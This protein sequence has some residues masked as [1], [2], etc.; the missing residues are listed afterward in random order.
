M[1]LDEMSDMAES[2]VTRAHVQKRNAFCIFDKGVEHKNVRLGHRLFMWNRTSIPVLA[3]HSRHHLERRY[4]DK[5]CKS[6]K[7][8]GER[9]RTLKC[10]IVSV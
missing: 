5:C 3:A 6:F 9:Q 7:S 2:I 1:A 8:N 4:F 10:G